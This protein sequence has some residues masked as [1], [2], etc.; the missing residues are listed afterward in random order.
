MHTLIQDITKGELRSAYVEAPFNESK[1]ILESNDYN[2]ISLEESLKLLVLGADAHFEKKFFNVSEDF[3]YIPE[4]GVY[5]SKKSPI[6]RSPDESTNNLGL[7]EEFYLNDSQIEMALSDSIFIFPFTEGSRYGKEICISTKD[8]KED[9]RNVYAFGNLVQNHEAFLNKHFPSGFEFVIDCLEGRKRPYAK[10]AMI[11]SKPYCL[12]IEGRCGRQ[13][14][15]KDNTYRGVRKL[16]R[17]D[18][19]AIKGMKKEE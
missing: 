1:E 12:R 18:N 15:N 2:L 5:L 14:W 7:D 6:Y 8:F 16:F 13:A 19:E 3:I 17:K 10:K 4:K 9:K 11:E